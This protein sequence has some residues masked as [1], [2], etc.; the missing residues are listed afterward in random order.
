MKEAAELLDWGAFDAQPKDARCGD[1]AVIVE[2]KLQVFPL[3]DE[4][5][6]GEP[7]F[8]GGALDLSGN[9]GGAEIGMAGDTDRTPAQA[10]DLIVAIPGLDIEHGTLREEPAIDEF[11]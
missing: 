10:F 8:I 2:E 5:G 1:G 9:G 6:F 4:A 7:C 3:S 11:G